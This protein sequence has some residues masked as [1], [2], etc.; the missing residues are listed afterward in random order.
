ML[1]HVPTASALIRAR[2]NLAN[3]ANLAKSAPSGTVRIVIDAKAVLAALDTPDAAS[4]HQARCSDAN[5]V[6]E[7]HQGQRKTGRI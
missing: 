6:S 4:V 2:S 7:Y 1:L 5:L 3:L